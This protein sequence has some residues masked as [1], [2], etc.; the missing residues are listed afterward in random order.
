MMGAKCISNLSNTSIY[1]YLHI[2]TVLCYSTYFSEYKPNHTFF[3]SKIQMI[4]CRV[5]RSF[6]LFV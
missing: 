1:R 2:T 6:D 4:Y 5:K 3:L